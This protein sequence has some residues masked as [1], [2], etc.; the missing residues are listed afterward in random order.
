[1]KRPNYNL[2]TKCVLALILVIDKGFDAFP[3]TEMVVE[4]LRDVETSQEGSIESKSENPTKYL[5]NKVLLN[6]EE[7]E[8]VSASPTDGNSTSDLT[9]DLLDTDSINREVS[10]DVK[11]KVTAKNESR[12]K[13]EADAGPTQRI[14]PR[15]KCIKSSL[16]SVFANICVLRRPKK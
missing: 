3:L 9:F 12:P 13:S 6:G 7:L 10:T 5:L 16:L 8:K 4:S 2:F 14:K 1:M 15:S 11:L